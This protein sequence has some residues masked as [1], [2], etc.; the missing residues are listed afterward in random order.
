MPKIFVPT[1]MRKHTENKATVEVPGTTVSE[2]FDNLLD[3][4]PLVRDLLRR[5]E[6]GL[7][8]HINVFVNGDDIRALDGEKTGLTDRD[9]VHVVPAMAGG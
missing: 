7:L 9:E 4:Y 5:K 8:P 2:V 6:G 3:S 1:I